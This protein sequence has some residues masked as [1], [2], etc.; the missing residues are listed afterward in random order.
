[1]GQ[2]LKAERSRFVCRPS[3]PCEEM[4]DHPCEE[5]CEEE[6]KKVAGQVGYL[7][8]RVKLLVSTLNHPMFGGKS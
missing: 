7:K 8:D 3:H 6:L 1:M 5:M 2:H 4:C